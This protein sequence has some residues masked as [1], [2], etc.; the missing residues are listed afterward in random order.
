MTLQ[1][2]VWDSFAKKLGRWD[3]KT[4]KTNFCPSLNILDFIMPLI[5]FEV[6]ISTLSNHFKMTTEECII[7]NKSTSISKKLMQKKKYL[8]LT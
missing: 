1:A 6:H 3:G 4:I 5:I 2:R 7:F 8:L